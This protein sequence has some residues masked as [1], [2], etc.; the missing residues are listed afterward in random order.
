[1]PQDAFTLRYLCRELSDLFSGGKINKIIQPSTD[2]VIFTVYN[3]KGTDKLFISVNPARPRIGVTIDDVKADDT[4]NFCL[5]LRKHLAGGTIK[6]ISLCGFDRIVKITI[7]PSKEFFDSAD[8]DLYVELMG[9][10]S[11]V[12]LTE[13]GKILGG[14]R[15]INMFDDG[16]RPLFVGQKYLFPPVGNKKEPLD[17]GLIE[18]LENIDCDVA[19]FLFSNVQGIAKDTATFIVNKFLSE[20]RMDIT[21]LC[22]YVKENAT[23]FYTYVQSLLYSNDYNPCVL[24]DGD[25][26]AD[27][28]VKPYFDGELKF[29]DK[30]YLAED[31]YFSLKNKRKRFSDKKDRITNLVNTAIKKASKRLNAITQKEKDALTL[32]DNRI[33][34]ELIL[35]N[36]YRIK[37][38]DKKVSLENYYNENALVEIDLDE[39]L[40]P[41]KNAEKY[42]K[43]YAKQKRALDAIK[44]QKQSAKEELDYYLSVA[45]S[46]SIAE[47]ENELD[48]LLKEIKPL[49]QTKGKKQT[50]NQ[51]AHVYEK[52]GFIIKVGRSNL[53]NDKLLSDANKDDVWLHVKDYHSSHDIISGAMTDMPDFI[54]KFGAEVCAYYSKC[55]QSD[56]VEVVYT[57]RRFVKKPKGAKPGFVTYD[58]FKSIIVAPKKHEDFIKGN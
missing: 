58:E 42:Y 18:D 1:M 56:K 19:D 5:L 22:T 39:N 10:Y 15:G 51:G 41:A 30:L 9:R 26:P 3:G 55:R 24:I 34:G 14:N 12:I 25:V 48:A 50:E 43:K 11:N 7:S 27:V 46:L 32:E 21:N 54:I 36:V 17:R 40:S 35:S 16:V 28:F 31:Y 44:P 2:D 4:P 13:N 20:K 45:D 53:E 6:D 38:G 49:P 29:F 37:Q 47:T 23:E 33:K 8:K 52:E 57:K